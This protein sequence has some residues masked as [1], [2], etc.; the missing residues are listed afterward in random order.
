LQQE[1]IAWLLKW[2]KKY[3]LDALDFYPEYNQFLHNNGYRL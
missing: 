3:N 1:L 2:D